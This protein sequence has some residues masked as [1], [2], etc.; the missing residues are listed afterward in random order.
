M[1]PAKK[2][3]PP[4]KKPSGKKKPLHERTPRRALP[5]RRKY[6][7]D[8]ILRDYLT[9]IVSDDG[10]K[11]SWRSLVDLAALHGV[12]LQTI[13]EAS[14]QEGW[15]AQQDNAR[16][17]WNLEVRQ[18]V[19]ESLYDQTVGARV[20]AFNGAMRV[21]TVA[22]AKL[23]GEPDMATVAKATRAIRDAL[24]VTAAAAGFQRVS[25]ASA[26][27]APVPIPVPSPMQL[28]VQVNNTVTTGVGAGG[29]GTSV[30]TEVVLTLSTLWGSLVQARRV[31]AAVVE[32][33]HDAPSP[34][35]PH[36]SSAR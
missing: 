18:R 20:L 19:D 31:Q 24:D 17:R 28:G 3:A 30:E 33:P 23:N 10:M 16:R 1:A 7:W 8:A 9:P 34:L 14:A 15:V 21:L 2:A 36:L 32:D 4:K 35:P 13:R 29:A 25:D 12:P 11:A 6:D 22:R 26:P 27:P 5:S